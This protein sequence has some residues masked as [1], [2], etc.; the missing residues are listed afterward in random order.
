MYIRNLYKHFSTNGGCCTGKSTTV[1]IWADDAVYLPGLAYYKKI[2][3]GFVCDK[4]IIVATD[5]SDRTWECFH[6]FRMGGMQ[7]PITVGHTEYVAADLINGKM[8]IFEHLIL[9]FRGARYIF[10]RYIS[11][12]GSKK[13]RK[14]RWKTRKLFSSMPACNMAFCTRDWRCFV[15]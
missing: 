12:T 6:I 1:D 15:G 7:E 9:L 10:F 8:N 14:R 5:M 3:K 13:L 2:R 11:S 4:S